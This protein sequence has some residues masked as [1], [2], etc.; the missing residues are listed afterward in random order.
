MRSA[1]RTI[2][3]GCRIFSGNKRAPLSVLSVDALTS[4]TQSGR[5][6]VPIDAKVVPPGGRIGRRH[7]RTP[8]TRED[9]ENA[10]DAVL[11]VAGALA[12]MTSLLMILIVA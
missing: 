5:S 7:M 9:W 8:K 3:L 6:V 11:P 10:I 2:L 12:A 4:A 1:D